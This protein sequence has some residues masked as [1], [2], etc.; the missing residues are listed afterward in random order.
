MLAGMQGFS[1]LTDAVTLIGMVRLVRRY[2]WLP[3][4]VGMLV[5][6]IAC[7]WLLSRLTAPLPGSLEY[8]FSR[9]QIGMSHEE[10][11]AL[12]P[13]DPWGIRLYGHG[14]TVD[15]DSFSFY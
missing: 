15:G 11:L 5:I 6:A 8:G 4:V 3:I 2:R 10:A 7:P 9:I 13:P 14:T 1:L 12:L